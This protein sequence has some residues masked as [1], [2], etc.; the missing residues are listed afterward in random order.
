VR[1]TNLLLLGVLLL[2]SLATIAS[3]NNSFVL[4]DGNTDFHSVLQ[5]GNTFPVVVKPF[6][7]QQ[8]PVTN[9]EYLQFVLA[10]PEWQRSKVASL[11]ATTEY[12]SHWA[13]ST[14]LGERASQQPVTRVS[15]FAA[16]AYCESIRSRLPTWYEWELAAAASETIKDARSSEEWRQRI[17]DWYATPAHDPLNEVMSTKPDIYG[18]YDL[19]RLIWEWVLDFNALMDNGEAQKFCG[20]G[21]LNL[22]QKENFAVLMRVAMLSSLHATDT[23]RTV[24]FRCAQDAAP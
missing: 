15:W 24:G 13:S 11:Y 5:S 7:L 21:A 16:Q 1:H 2:F 3:E 19:H 8:H 6:R 17:L 18:I 22:Q 9:A 4:I 12:L 23:S 10:H 20:G 14:T